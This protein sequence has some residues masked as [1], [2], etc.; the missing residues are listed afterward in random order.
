MEWSTGNPDAAQSIIRRSAG[1]EGSGGIA[2]L[3]AK[4]SLE[5]AIQETPVSRWSE[6][7]AWIKLRAL[8]ELLTSSAEAAL[9]YLDPQLKALQEGSVEYERLSVALLS[10]LY[11]HAVV[12]IN[13]TPPAMLRDRAAKA[14]EAYPNNTIL[15]G[16]FLEGEKGQ[17][18]WGRVRAMLGGGGSE[19][20][21]QVGR[22]KD[23]ARR[24]AEVWVAGWEKSRWEAEKERTRSGLAA[25]VEDERYVMAVCCGMCILSHL[26]TRCVL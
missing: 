23:V 25:A 6:R 17:G 14:L 7:E 26:I 13:P 19:G 20:R 9:A 1:A 10:I 21:G 4:R 16:F 8:L 12:L 24:V 5:D 3:R 2:T 22:E 15:L 18:V 11:T